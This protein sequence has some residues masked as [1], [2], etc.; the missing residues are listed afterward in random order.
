MYLLSLLSM[1]AHTL[2]ILSSC[3]YLVSPDVMIFISTYGSLKAL[4]SCYYQPLMID[5]I[6][7]FKFSPYIVSNTWIPSLYDIPLVC[8]SFFIGFLDEGFSKVGYF[9]EGS[10]E[11]EESFSLERTSSITFSSGW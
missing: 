4:S 6:F 9:E 10:S 11:K 3:G 2:Q 1:L 8:V 5:F 7:S